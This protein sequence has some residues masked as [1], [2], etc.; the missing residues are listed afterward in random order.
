MT[1]S[2]VFGISKDV[3]SEHADALLGYLSDYNAKNITKS[4]QLLAL[5]LRRLYPLTLNGEQDLLHNAWYVEFRDEEQA[6]G[7][8][9]QLRL[10]AQKGE[11]VFAYQCL[12][13]DRQMLI[14]AGKAHWEL[15][16][17]HNSMNCIND[18]SPI[19]VSSL[20]VINSYTSNFAESAILERLTNY[21][22]LDCGYV[23]TSTRTLLHTLDLEHKW[24]R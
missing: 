21:I 13:S 24:R 3:S 7:E 8:Y 15:S 17:I 16:K 20:S 4:D 1:F 9:L 22:M 19:Y 11:I 23:L 14:E 6:Q 2:V 5:A 18:R 10:A 12:L